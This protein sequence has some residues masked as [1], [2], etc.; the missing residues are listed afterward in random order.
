MAVSEEDCRR[1]ALRA[2][3]FP[4]GRDGPKS[5]P[6]LAWKTRMLRLLQ[7]DCRIGQ[8]AC[9]T[10]CHGGGRRGR[11][12]GGADGSDRNF[13]PASITKR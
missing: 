4:D 9:R 2:H 3:R 1:P 5:K 7:G 12:A 13:S 11:A 8:D 6:I 10:L